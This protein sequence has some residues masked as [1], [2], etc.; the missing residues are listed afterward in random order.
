MKETVRGFKMDILENEPDVV[1]EVFDWYETNFGFVPNLTKVLSAAPAA[2]R[3]YWLAQLELST[4]GLLTPAEH[5]I[6]QMSVAVE[7]RCRYCA[8]GHQMAVKE[9]FGSDKEELEAIR[10]EGIIPTEKFDALRSFALAVYRNKGRIADDILENFL[11][12]GYSKAQAV[13]VITNIGVK[14]MSNLTNQLAMTE[15]DEP[16]VP[17]AE[18]LFEQA[19][20]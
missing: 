17:L 13:E 11:S 4:N 18:G 15:V 2:V 1:K 9:F 20:H 3:A 6:I 14:V 16:F 10:N 7:N 8:S 12:V 5:N 19:N